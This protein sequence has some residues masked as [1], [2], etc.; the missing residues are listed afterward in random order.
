MAFW[1]E[2]KHDHDVKTRR[3][4]EEHYLGVPKRLAGMAFGAGET[5]A[6]SSAEQLVSADAASDLE[7]M[8]NGAQVGGGGAEVL[9]T[10]D[11]IGTTHQ[12]FDQG[13]GGG[14]GI[15]PNQPHHGGDEI[16]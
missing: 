16:Y 2:Q 12:K 10:G 11:D 7:T 1:P 15:W 13:G 4:F 5:K 9:P 14:V 3:Y 8:V 6:P